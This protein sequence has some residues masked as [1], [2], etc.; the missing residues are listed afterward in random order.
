MQQ[1]KEREN[2]MQS[3]DMAKECAGRRIFSQRESEHINPEGG[4]I[5]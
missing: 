5:W 1:E 3:N 2:E 4:H